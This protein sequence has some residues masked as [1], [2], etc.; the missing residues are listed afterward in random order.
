MVRKERARGEVA[1]RLLWD[2]WNRQKKDS[3]LSERV[4]GLLLAG[5]DEVWVSEVVY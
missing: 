5:E 4:Q 2:I 3:E 1:R